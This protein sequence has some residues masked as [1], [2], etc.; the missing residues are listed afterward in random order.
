MKGEAGGEKGV[1]AEAQQKVIALVREVARFGGGY[2]FAS[3]F[4]EGDTLHVFA[5]EGTNFDWF[6]GIA[7]FSSKDLAA[8]ERRPAIA[9]AGLESTRP[10]CWRGADGPRPRRVHGRGLQLRRRQPPARGPPPSPFRVAR[11]V[12]PTVRS[13]QAYPPASRRKPAVSK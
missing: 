1:S 13:R 9:P 10:D 2:S 11:T 8:W 7:H 6:Q 4:V 5:S 3:A 12:E